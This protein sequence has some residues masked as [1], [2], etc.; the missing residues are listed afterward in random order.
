MTQAHEVVFPRSEFNTFLHAAIG[1]EKNGM[2][3]S[4]ASALARFG[5]D[6]WLEAARLAGLPKQLAIDGLGQLLDR[7]PE[8]QWQRSGTA[9]I[10]ARL[11]ALLP[12]VGSL[13]RPGG[14]KTKSWASGGLFATLLILLALTL[15]LTV[16]GTAWRGDATPGDNRAPA[17]LS[18]ILDMARTR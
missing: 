4:V 8:D 1:E 9:S 7:L 14:S 17:G 2:E 5:M 3:L 6:P 11:V 12:Q 15:A 16:F 18:G 13:A 10:A